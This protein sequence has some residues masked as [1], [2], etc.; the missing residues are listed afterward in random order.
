MDFVMKL[1]NLIA[2]H[3]NS[4]QGSKT[5]VTRKHT[6]ITAEKFPKTC[7]LCDAKVNNKKELKLHMKTHSY[8][9]SNFQCEDCDFCGPNEYIMEVHAGRCHSTD[10]E[11][12]LCDYKAKDVES[13]RIHLNT[14]EIYECDLCYFRVMQIS[15]MKSHMENKNQD[16]DP[17]IWHVTQS[18]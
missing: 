9:G 14:C 15:E 16:S 11:C 12:G 1:T 5:H 7:D 17:R 8:R 10:K 18:I 13:L 2:Q 6:E 4:Q 3:V